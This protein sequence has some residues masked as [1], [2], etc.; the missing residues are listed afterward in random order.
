VPENEYERDV[1]VLQGVLQAS[2]G[3]TVE[4][5]SRC[6]DDEEVTKPLIEEELRHDPRV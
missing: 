6:P 3:P 4:D 1:E 5:M 2:Y